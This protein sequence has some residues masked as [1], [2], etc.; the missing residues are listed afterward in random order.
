MSGGSFIF[1]KRSVGSY[2]L[3]GS[4]LLLTESEW[5]EIYRMK[6]KIPGIWDGAG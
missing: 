2:R 1:K 3:P 4:N 5:S 6:L